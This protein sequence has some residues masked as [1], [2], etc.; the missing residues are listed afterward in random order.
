[1][2]DLVMGAMGSLVPKLGELLKEEYRL[3]TGVKERI[4]SLTQELELAQA[5]LR[6]V[7]WDQLDE[8]VQIW[9]RQV[10]EASYDMEDVLDTFLVRV[11]GP[12]SAEQEKSFLKSLKKMVNLFK[13]SKARRKIS[14]DVKDIMSHLHEVT[15]RCRRYKVDDI[16]ARQATTSTID[17]RLH[18]MYTQVDRL[19]GIDKSSGELKSKLQLDDMSNKKMKTV[20]IV[21]IGGLGKTTLAKAVYDNLGGDFNC[22]SFVSVGRNP[23]LQKVLQMILISLHKKRYEKF[24]FAVLQDITQFIDELREFLHDKR[25]AISATQLRGPLFVVL[26]SCCLIKPII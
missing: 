20:S 22:R 15:E 4:S 26:F 10:R 8:Q 1:M 13:K 5:A 16:V 25:Y 18:A 7:P 6:K 19:V 9:A 23:D 24:N 3:Q 2:A 11:Q 12:D 21:G 17:P 14:G